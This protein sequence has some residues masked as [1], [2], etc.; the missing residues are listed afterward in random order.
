MTK[1]KPV[2]EQ[3]VFQEHTQ[4]SEYVLF[5]DGKD[6]F[7]GCLNDLSGIDME[8]EWVTSTGFGIDNVTHWMPLPELPKSCPITP[9]PKPPTK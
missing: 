9:E 1:W 8:N 6:I 5:T 2:S 3:P 7:L 4:C